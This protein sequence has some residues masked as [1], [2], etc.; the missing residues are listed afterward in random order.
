M[1]EVRECSIASALEIVGERWSLLALRE[2]LFGVRRFDQIVRNT[3]A[4]RDILATRL[5]KLVDTGLLEKRLYEERPR[6]YEYVPTESGEA[7]QSVLL[8]LMS[9]GD[10]YATAGPPPTVWQHSCGAVLV[11]ETVCGGCGERIRGGENTLLRTTRRSATGESAAG[12]SAGDPA[13]S[14]ADPADGAA[15][16][17]EPAG[18]VEAAR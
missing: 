9:W 18:R 10:R 4:S 16:V 3:G 7:L 8:T 17:V 5:R 14:D 13:G 11:P 15:A 1:S 12:C 6:R 2:V